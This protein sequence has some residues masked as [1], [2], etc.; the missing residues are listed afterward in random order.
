MFPEKEGPIMRRFLPF[1]ALAA[2]VFGVRFLRR[3]WVR[4]N[5]DLDRVRAGGPAPRAT[6]RRD[7]R[8]GEWRPSS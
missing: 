7:A 2:A 5:R 3:E 1:A 6:L 4:V 8:T